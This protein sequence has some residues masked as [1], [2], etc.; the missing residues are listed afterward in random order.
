MHPPDGKVKIG[1]FGFT[2]RL[3]QH[4]TQLKVSRV[5]HPRWASPEV[6][7][8]EGQRACVLSERW[9]QSQCTLVMHARVH[10]CLS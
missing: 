5:T 2:K 3:A 10:A 1:D 6:R 4:T 8:G 9:L 7:V